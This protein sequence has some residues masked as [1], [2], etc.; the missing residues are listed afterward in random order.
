M[1]DS[2]EKLKHGSSESSSVTRH[3]LYG[4]FSALCFAMIFASIGSIIIFKSHAAG[5][6]SLTLSP[7]SGSYTVGSTLTVSVNETSTDSV[8]AVEA[9]LTYNSSQLQFT[10]ASCS[11]TFSLTAEATGSGGTVNLACARENTT[12]TGAQTVGTVSFTVLSGVSSSIISFASTSQIVNESNLTNDWN[13]ITTGGTYSF[14]SA[15]TDTVTAPATG[16]NV[17]G[18]NASVTVN[19]TDV[20]GVSKVEMFINGNLYATDTSAPYA[21]TWNTLSGSYPDAAYSVTT[22]AF[23]AAGLT[24][25]SPAISLKVNNGDVNGDDVVNISDLSILATNWSKSFGTVG[26]DKGSSTTFAEGDLNQ[27]NTV[28]IVDL[29][30]LAS[31]WGATN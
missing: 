16:T 29:S 9:D 1:A 25:T 30:I 3:K 15:P 8:N 7:A 11:T 14:A 5:S 2:D 4:A 13:G 24:A 21:F 28:N 19:A 31:N 18:D 20:I 10:G 26:T 6:S 27:D 22:E 17:H 12:V 23:D